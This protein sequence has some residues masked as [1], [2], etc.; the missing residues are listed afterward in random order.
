MIT[1]LEELKESVRLMYPDN[2]YLANRIQKLIDKL[3]Q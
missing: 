2:I 1:E 3:K